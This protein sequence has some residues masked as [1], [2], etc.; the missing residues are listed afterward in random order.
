MLLNQSITITIW[1]FKKMQVYQQNNSFGAILN[2]VGE[3]TLLTR[4]DK[5]SKPIIYTNIKRCIIIV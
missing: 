5:P 4:G 2:C 1:K 3:N